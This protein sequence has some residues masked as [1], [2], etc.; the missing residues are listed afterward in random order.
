MPTEIFPDVKMVHYDDNRF[1]EGW[2]RAG[3]KVYTPPTRPAVEKIQKFF[4]L[5]IMRRRWE[6]LWRMLKG[7]RG[8]R[9]GVYDVVYAGGTRAKQSRV[10]EM[11]GMFL[12]RR[13]QILFDVHEVPEAPRPFSKYK[14]SMLQKVDPI[15]PPQHF[16]DLAR[17]NLM[18][19]KIQ[20]YY[21]NME[22]YL[23]DYYEGKKCLLHSDAQHRLL[24]RVVGWWGECVKQKSEC[25]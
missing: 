11:Q 15:V 2:L 14:L 5:M 23:H 16:V 21:S 12:N 3:G 20:D 10:I 1:R 19:K 13:D 6:I 8:C 17:K 4:R 9:N 18:A 7:L 22:V 25:V 24:G